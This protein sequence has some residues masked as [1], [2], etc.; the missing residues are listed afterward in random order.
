METINH[1][2]VTVFGQPAE[3][4]RWMLIPLGMSVLLCLGSVYSW[5]IFRKPLEAE[6]DIS[7]T[8]SLMPYTI[9]LV[10]YAT[11][12]PIAGFY[13]PRVGT[14]MM[15]AIGGIVVGMGY[16]L[17]SFATHIG[18]IILAYGVIAGTGVG[19]AYG[20]PMAVVARWF[21]DQKGLAV[22][23]TIIGFGLSPLITAPL[24]N[25][26]ID[27]YTVRPA[28][29]ILGIAFMVIIVGIATTLKLPPADWQ[30]WQRQAVPANAQ[31]LTYPVML[32][33]RSFYGLWIC[34]A[35]GTLIGL[36]AIGISSPVGEE[37]IE[38]EPGLAAS[39]VSLFAL[40]N[41]ASRPLFG[42][43]SDRLKPHYV[44]IASYM[45]LLIACVLMVNAETGQIARYLMAF[46]LFWFCLGGWLAMAPTITL[47][48]FDP[49]QY[50][51]HYGIV[52]TAYG[53]G[54]LIGT[55][56]TGRIRDWFGTYT[57]AFYP[58]AL[59]AI[60]GM[61]VASRLLKREHL[62]QG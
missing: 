16:I 59:L 62:P 14:R 19:I 47:R 52:F 61:I 36:S 11:L 13:I 23:L 58:M 55:L 15:T 17:A 18:M 39:S 25:Q 56:V 28:L 29:R 24:A 50:A 5:S 45:L 7:A 33:S 4:G 9:A 57:Y 42:W 48:F 46:C 2:E 51:Q 3:R 22:G 49:N 41:G 6:L 44:A 60:I 1:D 26:L 37:I 34:Y 30:P 8:E 53:V 54:A 35:I 38:I 10:F 20:V 21:P 27:A 40:F 31:R 12:M 43:L 32:K